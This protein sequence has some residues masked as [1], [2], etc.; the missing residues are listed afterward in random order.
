MHTKVDKVTAALFCFV[1]VVTRAV[2]SRP[3]RRIVNWG[4][5][6][7]NYEPLGRVEVR[8]YHVGF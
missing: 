7:P 4:L 6:Q 5:V 8:V 2:G 1:Y 3:N